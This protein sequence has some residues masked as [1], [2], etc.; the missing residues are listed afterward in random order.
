MLCTPSL[1]PRVTLLK[2]KS[3]P[4]TKASAHLQVHINLYFASDDIMTVFPLEDSPSHTLWAHSP[5]E[6]PGNEV[7]PFR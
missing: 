6:E 4:G 2:K 1:S 7:I 3:E 5:K